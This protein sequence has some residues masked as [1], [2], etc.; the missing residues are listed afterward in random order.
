MRA[1]VAGPLTVLAENDGAAY[2][3]TIETEAAASVRLATTGRFGRRKARAEHHAA[4]EQA[5]AARASMRATWVEPPRTSESL[6]A[7]AVQAAARRA[8]NDPR[9]TDANRAV[10]TAHARHRATERRHRQERLALLTS[11]LGA[12]EARRDQFGMRTIS[13]H[14]NAQD[15]RAIVALARTEADELRSLPVHEAAR[16]I[17]A[18][19]GEQEHARRRAAQRARQLDPFDREPRRH[20]PGHNGPARNL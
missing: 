17:E 20:D 3:A 16:R 11:E 2:L 4:T 10:E 15:A 18:N 6:S 5:G 8:E 19:R 13:P 14:R 12:D 1:E 7:W 9:V